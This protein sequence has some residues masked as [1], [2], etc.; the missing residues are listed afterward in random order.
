MDPKVQF[1]DDIKPLQETE[2][3]AY[4]SAGFKDLT[5]SYF[6]KYT[7]IPINFQIAVTLGF[8][9]RTAIAGQTFYS[10][11]LDT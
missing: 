8:L 5:V 1:I 3:A 9:V 10:F 4:T 2:L 11:T 7:G 6:L